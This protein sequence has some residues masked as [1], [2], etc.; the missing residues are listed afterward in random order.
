MLEE[1]LHMF[2]VMC[3]TYR[4]PSIGNSRRHIAFY[5]RA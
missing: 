5:A 1:T 4:M 2:T 3:H